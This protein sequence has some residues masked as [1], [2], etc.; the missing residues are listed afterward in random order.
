M[1]KNG[2]YMEKEW[3]YFSKAITCKIYGAKKTALEFPAF[4]E[5]NWL[6]SLVYCPNK[7]K[8]VNES[9]KWVVS[10]T[11]GKKIGFTMVY[12][13]LFYSLLYFILNNQ[14][15]ALA[16]NAIE[17]DFVSTKHYYFFSLILL[18]A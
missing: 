11:S 16:K 14:R 18:F 8:R 4:Q 13:F 3:L 7:K 9:K 6:F 12:V 2:L 17:Y 10:K 5:I 15:F 1:S